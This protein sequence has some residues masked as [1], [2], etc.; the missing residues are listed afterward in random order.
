MDLKIGA[1]FSL[2]DLVFGSIEIGIILDGRSGLLE[3]DHEITII[4]DS[5]SVELAIVVGRE[6]LSQFGVR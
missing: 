4:I 6:W 3:C 5:G 2:T 1:S